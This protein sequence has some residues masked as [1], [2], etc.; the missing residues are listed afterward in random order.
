MG[1]KQSARLHRQPHAAACHSHAVKKP[2]LPIV[3]QLGHYT[4]CQVV[5]ATACNSMPQPR[6]EEAWL[7]HCK[8][9]WHYTRCQVALATACSSKPQLCCEE[10]WL[11][12][13]KPTWAL[14]KVPGCTDNRVQQH[15]TA[16]LCRSL[17]CL[18]QASLGTIQ[19]ARLHWQPYTA[20]CH[21]YAVKKPGLPTA[22]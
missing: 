12:H 7:A 22:S 10:A 9:T 13:C 5:L 21:S 18:L 1:T 17:A 16:T 20:A 3:S 14:N 6:C 15:V 8:L 19:S 4:K 11:A 2:G